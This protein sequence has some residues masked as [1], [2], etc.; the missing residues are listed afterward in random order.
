MASFIQNIFGLTINGTY[1]SY[2]KRASIIGVSIYLFLFVEFYSLYHYYINTLREKKSNKI[3]NAIRYV[4]PLI[5]LSCWIP[6]NNPNACKYYLYLIQAGLLLLPCL[7]F[8]LEQLKNPTQGDL[9]TSAVFWI[10]LGV[11]FYFAC[12]LPLFL[13]KDFVFHPLGGVLDE[14]AHLI[15]QLCY[16]IMFLIIL[17]GYKCHKK[18]ILQ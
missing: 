4:Y 3:L 8:I 1:L 6:G 15:N 12:T 18:Q 7:L 9:H 14:R 5:P 11:A 16:G 2:A 10:T 17:K 13:M